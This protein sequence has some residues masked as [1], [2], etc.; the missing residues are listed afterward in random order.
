MLLERQYS[1][2]S[3]PDLIPKKDQIPLTPEDSFYGH[4][5][6]FQTSALLE[7]ARES[8]RATLFSLGSDFSGVFAHGTPQSPLPDE[9]YYN[10]LGPYLEISTV[11]TE[12]EFFA[13]ASRGS[14]LSKESFRSLVDF[15]QP[16][17]KK[18]EGRKK[19]LFSLQFCPS[20]FFV[21]FCFYDSKK[22][23]F[24]VLCSNF[25]CFVLVELQRF[26][27]KEKK[28]NWNVSFPNKN[29]TL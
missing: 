27:E 5:G 11:N 1:T 14:I 16:P 20:S 17:G 6:A 18:S 10:D 12:D 23:S 19:K 13:E 3:E 29:K 9:S 28:G 25:F 22:K 15:L 2:D 4:D 26:V 8:E 24:F 7:L 21:L